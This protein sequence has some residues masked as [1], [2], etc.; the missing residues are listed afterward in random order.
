ML[1]RNLRLKTWLLLGI[2]VLVIVAGTLVGTVR[3]LDRAVPG[4]RAQTADWVSERIGQPLAIGAMELGWTWT[5]P[6]LHF[7][8]VALLRE[9][10]ARPALRLRGLGLHFGFWD[11]LRGIREPDRLLISGVE[12]TLHRDGDGHWRLR[13]LGQSETRGFDAADIDRWLDRVHFTRIE[14]GHV[15][16]TDAAH[17]DLALDV[18]GIAGTLRNKGPR[19]RARIRAQLPPRIGERAEIDVFVLGDFARPE[20]LE[21]H[22][23]VNAEGLDG[24]SLLRAAG[25]GDDAL[26]G[27]RA[28]LEAWSDWREGDFEGARLTLATESFRLSG[29]P[30]RTATTLDA[31]IEPAGGDGG[32]R[33]RLDAL[34]TPDGGALDTT[35]EALIAPDGGRIE[36]RLASLPAGLA[37]GWLKLA[38]P[39][40]FTDTAADGTLETLRVEYAGEGDWRADGRF[41]GLTLR[42]AP[43]GLEA[44]RFGGTWS[45]DGD[46]G[47]LTLTEG[48]GGITL[49]RY[50]RG[51]LPLAALGGELA[52][53][54]TADGRRLTMSGLR[55]AAAG[56]EIAGGGTLELPDAGPPVADL[57]FDVV[58]DDLPAVL[59]HIP[60]AE[61]LPNP[62]LRDWLPD[63]IG[64]GRLTSGQIRLAG[65]LDR[66]PLAGDA[67]TFRITAR[68][69]GVDLTYKPGWPSLTAVAGRLVID[70]DD[71]EIRA[72]RGRMLGVAAGPAT[73]RIANVREPVLKVD[74]RVR[75]GAAARM[76]DFLAESPL[77]ERFGRL[78]EVLTLDGA[79][80]LTLDLS[81]PLKPGLGEPRVNGAVT[82]AGLR[83]EHDALPAPLTG[84]AG[85]LRFDLD[86]LYA[87]GLTAELAGLPLTADVAPGDGDTLRI[88]ARTTLRLPEHAETL[89]AFRLPA[90]IVAA[91][92]GETPW[93][94]ALGIGGGG[95]ASALT[96]T[97]DLAG[98]A[99]KLPAPLA[100]PAGDAVP[101][102]VTI[103]GDRDRVRVEHGER[104]TLDLRFD[105]DGLWGL[106]AILGGGDTE[107]APDGPGWWIGGTADRLDAGAWRDL[108][109]D[110]GERAENDGGGRL[111]L[112]GA[113]LE[114]GELRAAG[115]RLK[116]LSLRITPLTADDGWRADLAGTAGRGTVRWLR[117]ADRD[118]I[119]ARLERLRLTPVPDTSAPGNDDAD[120]APIDPATLPLLDVRVEALA[121]AGDDFGHLDLNTTPLADGLSLDTLDVDGGVMTLRATGDWRRT[122]GL[123]RASLDAR[124]KGSGIAPLLRTL[125]YTANLRADKADIEAELALA[126]NPDG[127]TPAT[128][129]GRLSLSMENG[130]LLAVEPGAGRVLGLVNF[131]ALPRRLLLDFR[132]VLGKGTTF[133]TLSGDF[134]IE[135]GDAYT[136]D[137][138]IRTPS[139]EIAIEGRVGLAAR[140]YD[141]RVTITPQVSGAAAIAGT[142][143]GGPA[144]GA[145]VWVAQQ[146]LDKPLGDLTR[147]SYHLT[148]SWDDPEIREPTAT[149]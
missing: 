15:R 61:D 121:L 93:R 46:G 52:W 8:D 87:E 142:V 43:L 83:A 17:P 4:Y 78:P 51:R 100:K 145:A 96:L 144:L 25:L 118:R 36:A 117:R 139:A 102:R 37:A 77:A 81:I 7:S 73:A 38:L 18:T 28:Q 5:G 3:L 89:A 128:L 134:R 32:Y 74:G 21:A 79:A 125:G 19:H 107:A 62:R 99:L 85:T 136:D 60:Q 116:D 94:I 68:G 147:V 13:G 16:I 114:I 113:D 34:R 66:F 6:V 75:D 29:T 80:D 126:P 148:G 69:E 10:D 58:S 70:G 129:D 109:A 88:D 76:L 131:Y 47:S 42:D 53:T 63:A 11:L 50:L 24:A 104:A 140:D 97:S 64:A 149:E 110:G 49:D 22:A 98:M 124:L 67:G 146:F 135:S 123:T 122:D 143:L 92:A 31:S 119:E 56:T 106:T 2:A 54:T 115:Q 20:N 12:L 138:V 111:A 55:L 103:A 112:R 127:L 133:D 40:R 65:P 86:G 141:Q 120:A 44:G 48:E 72:E 9:E 1:R 132:D 41:A 57:T 26:R 59:A 130:N 14:D 105:A 91:A 101:T 108:L 45:V 95:R 137:L 90:R 84:I 71:L 35:G 27:G 30:L 23:Y 33:A 82:V 39:A